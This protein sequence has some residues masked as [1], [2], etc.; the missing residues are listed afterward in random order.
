MLDMRAGTATTAL[1]DQGKRRPP[2]SWTRIC[3]PAAFQG[4]Q[5]MA[6]WRPIPGAARR[7]PSSSVTAISSVARGASLNRPPMPNIA[8]GPP[9]GASEERYAGDATSA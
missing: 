5:R 9:S 8:E 6:A 7:Q 1:F 3:P 4:R 2:G